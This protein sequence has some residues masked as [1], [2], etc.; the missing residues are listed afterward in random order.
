MHVDLL[1]LLIVALFFVVLIYY[2][3]KKLTIKMFRR[4]KISHI[5]LSLIGI[6]LLLFPNIISIEDIN[7]LMS[8][9]VVIFSSAQIILI[10]NI[11]MS[12]KRHYG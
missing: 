10:L 12:L 6:L 9:G 3:I 2:V 11:P 8:Y 7:L 4:L 1:P 5:I